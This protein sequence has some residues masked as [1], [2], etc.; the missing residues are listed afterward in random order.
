M[1]LRCLVNR[2]QRP[3]ISMINSCQLAHLYCWYML[4]YVGIE[5]SP[6]TQQ[7]GGFVWDLLAASSEPPASNQS[8]HRFLPCLIVVMVGDLGK[9][10][11]CLANN[12]PPCL[13]MSLNMFESSLID[14]GYIW[15]KKLVL[16]HAILRFPALNHSLDLAGGKRSTRK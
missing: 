8:P 6:A 7:S 3:K 12:Q 15:V 11:G 13:I 10:S 14:T 2:V 1:D 4:V 5:Q 9:N 16:H